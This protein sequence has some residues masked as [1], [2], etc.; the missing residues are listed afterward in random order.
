[1]MIYRVLEQ[2]WTEDKALD[3]AIKIGTTTETLKKF[4]HDYIAQHTRNA[5]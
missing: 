4:A 1:M 3:E 2:G 5:G